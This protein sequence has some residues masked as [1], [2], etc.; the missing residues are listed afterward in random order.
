MN[1]SNVIKFPIARRFTVELRVQPDSSLLHLIVE[2]TGQ[3]DPEDDSLVGVPLDQIMDCA[4]QGE[5]KPNSLDVLKQ[6]MNI[7]KDSRKR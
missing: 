4:V 3:R 5:Y 2:V 7:S 6:A 1:A